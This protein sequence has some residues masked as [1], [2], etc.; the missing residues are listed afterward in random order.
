MLLTESGQVH[1][2][3]RAYQEDKGWHYQYNDAG[4]EHNA[5]AA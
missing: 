1:D 4:T 2:S 3:V 5:R